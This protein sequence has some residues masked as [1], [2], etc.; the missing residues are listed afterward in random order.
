MKESRVWQ[1][2]GWVFLLAC[3]FICLLYFA[4]VSSSSSPLL[5]S[6]LSGCWLRS[7]NVSEHK[8]KDAHFLKGTIKRLRFA[9]WF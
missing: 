1:T 8:A 4:L 5:L 7:K 9:C 6:P 2:S 3:L